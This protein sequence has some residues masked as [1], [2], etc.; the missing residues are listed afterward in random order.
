MNFL[1]HIYLTMPNAEL[2]IGNFI[3]DFVK[4][5]DLERFPQGIQQGI[6]VHRKIDEFTDNHEVVKGSKRKLWSKYGHYSGVIV[7]MFYDHFLAANWTNFSNIS[8]KEFTE[9]F[10][11]LTNDFTTYIP[12]KAQTMLRYMKADNWLYHYQSIDGIGTALT[13]LSR[14]TAFISK[15]ENASADLEANYSSFQQDFR[16]F[17]PQLVRFVKEI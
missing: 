14:R 7:D 9:S 2:T 3:G 4:G 10:Y 6:R 15:M 16:Q 12:Q 8:L 13:G 1:A 5:S 17:F 11:D